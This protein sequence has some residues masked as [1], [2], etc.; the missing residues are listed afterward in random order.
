MTQAQLELIP[1]H[2]LQPGSTGCAQLLD[3]LQARG[4]SMSLLEV[5]TER[6]RRG[7]RKPRMKGNH[8]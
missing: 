8:R 2:L 7:F 6:L 5:E 1:D 4:W 3:W